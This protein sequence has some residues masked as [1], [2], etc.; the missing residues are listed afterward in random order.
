VTEI[1][2]GYMLHCISIWVPV[3]QHFI[4][5]SLYTIIAQMG[6]LL[7]SKEEHVVVNLFLSWHST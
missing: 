2:F 4:S 5:M 7:H 3:L 1:I 6:Y